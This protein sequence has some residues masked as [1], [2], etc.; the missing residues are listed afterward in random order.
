MNHSHPNLEEIA[1]ND[2]VSFHPRRPRQ[3]RYVGMRLD[4]RLLDRVDGL[5]A[6]LNTTRSAIVR[7]LLIDLLTQDAE[8]RQ[9]GERKHAA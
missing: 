9:D 3:N 2:I 1:L 6:R 8:Q 4:G 5:A 7:R